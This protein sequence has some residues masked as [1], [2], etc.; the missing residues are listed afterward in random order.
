MLVETGGARALQETAEVKRAEDR[1][2]V[3]SGMVVAG[4]RRQSFDGVGQAGQCARSWVAWAV[5]R[6]AVRSLRTARRTARARHAAGAGGRRIPRSRSGPAGGGPGTV[7]RV[8][9]TGHRRGAQHG[10]PVRGAHPRPAF[11]RG[12]PGDAGPVQVRADHRTWSRKSLRSGATRGVGPWPQATGQAASVSSRRSS[13]RCA[14]GDA[15][16][17]VQRRGVRRV[18]AWHTTVAR[19]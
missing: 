1:A 3:A 5:A 13:A 19:R 7:R 14:V 10:R 6:R 4:R 15:R 9:V 17:G 16:T 18:A 8:T 11:C 2:V 12:R